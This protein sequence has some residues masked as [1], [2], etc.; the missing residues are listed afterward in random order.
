MEPGLHARAR[1]GRG[2]PYVYTVPGGCALAWLVAASD[3]IK[4]R[5]PNMI[6][7]WMPRRLASLGTDGFGAERGAALHYVIFFEV[8]SKFI[9]LA[10]A[11]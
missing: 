9:T 8:D 4:D 7:K 11:A 6:A 10:A 2:W 3:Y 1:K 5:F